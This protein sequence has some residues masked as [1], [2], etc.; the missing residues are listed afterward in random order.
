[1]R[2]MCYMGRVQILWAFDHKGEGWSVGG[3]DCVE[4]HPEDQQ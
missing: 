4:I 2:G 1:M 3:D